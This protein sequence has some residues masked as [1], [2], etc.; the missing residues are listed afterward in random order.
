MTTAEKN[1]P[2]GNAKTILKYARKMAKIVQ[3]KTRNNSELIE[4]E[5]IFFFYALSNISLNLCEYPAEVINKIPVYLFNP[6][7]AKR[8]DIKV[9]AFFRAKNYF[10]M[11]MNHS[12]K[13]TI[14]FIQD[15]FQFLAE[16]TAYIIYNNE[17]ADK[18]TKYS[19]LYGWIIKAACDDLIQ[20]INQVLVNKSNLIFN[21]LSE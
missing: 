21:F 19:F 20:K 3:K 9:I 2:E 13:I 17:L 15:A 5:F 1:T 16:L 18:N 7:E 10:T 4:Y 11:C 14:E 12:E 6:L 8:S